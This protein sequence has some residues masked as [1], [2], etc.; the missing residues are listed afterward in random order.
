[1]YGIP[2]LLFYI[3]E[4]N[5]DEVA[6]MMQKTFKPF[7]ALVDRIEFSRVCEERSEIADYV[8]LQ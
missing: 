1:M 3:P 5:L 8:Q 6:E 7:T 4:T 2:I